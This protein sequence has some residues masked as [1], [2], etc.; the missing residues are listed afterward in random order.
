MVA[1]MRQVHCSPAAL[2][3]DPTAVRAVPSYLYSAAELISRA[4]DLS[5][6]A[7]FSPENDRRW[8]VFGKGVE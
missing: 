6:A 8:R 3:A 2:R 1:L 4:A 7:P 5:V